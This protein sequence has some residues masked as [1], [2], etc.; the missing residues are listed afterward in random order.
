LIRGS[1]DPPPGKA[2]PGDSA[3]GYDVEL[4]TSGLVLDTHLRLGRR[5]ALRVLNRAEQFGSSGLTNATLGDGHER[6]KS[7]KAR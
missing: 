7:G 1:S 3:V 4:G 6:G 2:T 5:E